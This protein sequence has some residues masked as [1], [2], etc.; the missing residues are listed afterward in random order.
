MVCR[1]AGLGGTAPIV[2]PGGDEQSDQPKKGPDQCQQHVFLGVPDVSLLAVVFAG[3]LR[4]QDHRETPL[5]ELVEDAEGNKEL[6]DRVKGDATR[7]A[8]VADGDLEVQ[9]VPKQAKGEMD[10]SVVVVAAPAKR[11]GDV[12]PQDCR[13]PEIVGDVGVVVRLPQCVEQQKCRD[14]AE[15]CLREGPTPLEGVAGRGAQ[16]GRRV[17]EVH[18]L[19]KPRPNA[20]QSHGRGHG[21]DQD[22][23]WLAQRNSACR[24]MTKLSSR[25]PT[26]R[27][28]RNAGGS[29]L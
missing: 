23:L 28:R 25:C 13:E 7:D 14:T 19:R 16:H 29:R 3:V 15:R 17:L 22:P 21:A 20:S 26:R 4:R 9:G 2:V 11:A 6:D 8:E 27:G 5:E 12:M 10:E 24:V 1:S 18:L